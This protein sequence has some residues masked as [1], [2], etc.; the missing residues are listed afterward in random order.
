M[1]RQRWFPEEKSKIV[2]KYLKDHQTLFD[3]AEDS[4]TSPVQISQWVKA[5]LDSL[6]KAFSG[7][8]K[9]R[10]ESIGKTCPK[11]KIGSANSKKWSRISRPRGFV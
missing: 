2:R 9:K 7:E 5:D 4:G 8:H 1:T 3:L 11:R 10:P 6:G